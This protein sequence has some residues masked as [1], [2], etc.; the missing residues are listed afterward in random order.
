ME[1]GERHGRL[2]CIGKDSSRD[3]RYYLF[4]CDC[5]NIKSIIEYNVRRGATKSCGCYQNDHPSH[6]KYGF[7]HTRIDNIYRTMIDRCS[8]PN[9]NRFYTYGAKGITVCDE[10][11]EDKTKF[12]EWAFANGYNE[13][14]TIDRIDNQKGYSPSN[15]R[16]VDYTTQANNKTTNRIIEIDDERHTMAEWA[17]IS[18]TASP[19]ISY[20]LK[21]GWNAKEAVF[22]K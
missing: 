10:W 5:G 7:S 1:I 4:K 18:G 11:K 21:K 3:S 6:L 9:N 2:V 17:R 12:F 13:R 22:G 14:L 20:R 8:N 19:R 15:C 16:W